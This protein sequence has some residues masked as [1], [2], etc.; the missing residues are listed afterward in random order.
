MRRELHRFS[1]LISP[2][3]RRKYF[4]RENSLAMT[5]RFLPFTSAYSLSSCVEIPEVL[6]DGMDEQVNIAR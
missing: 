3:V 2:Q 1:K 5:T 4:I 6:S